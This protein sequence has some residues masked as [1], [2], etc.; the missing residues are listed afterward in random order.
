M[1][2]WNGQGIPPPFSNMIVAD[3]TMSIRRPMQ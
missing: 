1:Q 2:N 3:S